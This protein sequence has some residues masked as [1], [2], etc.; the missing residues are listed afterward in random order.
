MNEDTRW[1]QRLNNYRKAFALLERS[2]AI[3]NPTE[4]ERAGII[5]FYEMA[6]ELSWKIMKDFLESKDIKTMFARDAI[7]H[8]FQSELIEEGGLW[9]KALDDRN[10]TSHTY[11]EETAEEVLEKIRTMYFPLLKQFLRVMENQIQ[12]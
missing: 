4:L 1:V 10:L 6:F 12:K 5:Q 2:L 11:A 7:K 3:E 8:A 9:L